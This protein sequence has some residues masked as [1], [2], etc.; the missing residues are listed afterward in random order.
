L[1]RWAAGGRFC[2]SQASGMENGTVLLAAAQHG[3]H[4]P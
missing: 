4:L 3:Q 2:V 1:P